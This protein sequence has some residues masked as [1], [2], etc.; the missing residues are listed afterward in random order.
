M[1]NVFG[2]I[3]IYMKTY[4]VIVSI[5]GFPEKGKDV[6]HNSNFVGSND[7]NEPGNLLMNAM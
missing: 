2:C 5:S 1:P 3:M 4:I 7:P 6:E